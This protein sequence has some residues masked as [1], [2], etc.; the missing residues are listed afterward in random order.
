MCLIIVGLT[1]LILLSED[2]NQGLSDLLKKHFYIKERFEKA[3]LP[4]GEI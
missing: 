3:L 4:Q 2:P 1:F